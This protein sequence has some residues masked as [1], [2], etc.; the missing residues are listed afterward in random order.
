MNILFVEDD[1]NA[2][3]LAR[4]LAERGHTVTEADNLL[5]AHYYLT[6]EPK[7]DCYDIIFFDLSL[8]YPPAHS[9]EKMNFTIKSSLVGWDYLKQQIL[10]KHPEQKSKVV[11]Y[12]AYS[13]ML[14]DEIG[15]ET[16]S[17][18]KI[19]NKTGPDIVEQAEKFIEEMKK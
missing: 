10:T 18:L 1:S 5:D 11:I 4:L 17:S 16:Y 6:I 8:P 3:E 2:I 15:E 19:V 12:S 13:R 14:N 9:L 7:I